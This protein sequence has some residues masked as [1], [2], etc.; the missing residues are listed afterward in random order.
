MDIRIL[1]L[2]LALALILG[3]ALAM[4]REEFNRKNERQKRLD[5]WRRRIEHDA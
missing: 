1:I 5:Y 3:L 4:W 2:G